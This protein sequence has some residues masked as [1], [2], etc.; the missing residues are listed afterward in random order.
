MRGS[1]RVLALLV[2]LAGAVPLNAD[3]DF[4]HK[5][6]R[7]T[8]LYIVTNLA[9]ESR[10]V[11]TIRS[12]WTNQGP[13]STHVLSWKDIASNTETLAGTKSNTNAIY[14]FVTNR[15]AET[16]DWDNSLRLVDPRLV[17]A[18]PVE[19]DMVWHA[20]WPK[21]E[22]GKDTRYQQI[23]VVTPT[24]KA[25]SAELTALAMRKGI[26]LGT[27]R[28]LAYIAAV[29]APDFAMAEALAPPSGIAPD[30]VDALVF[31]YA[32]GRAFLEQCQ[33]RNEAW[34]IDGS[35][36]LTLPAAVRRALP[37]GL[38]DVA[39]SE[40]VVTEASVKPDGH[41]LRVY[42]APVTRHLT[43]L[44]A[45]PQPRRI[46]LADLRDVTTIAFIGLRPE[47]YGAQHGDI[48]WVTTQITEKLFPLARAAGISV[49]ERSALE[50]LAREHQIALSGYVDESSAVEMGKWLSAK[51]VLL[52]VLSDLSP[53]TQWRVEEWKARD[54]TAEKWAWHFTQHRQEAARVDGSLRL[55]S[56]ETGEQLWT[57]PLQA[58]Y[59]APD[60]A[61]SEIKVDEVADRKPARPA[62]LREGTENR[63]SLDA[64]SAGIAEAMTAF[65][66]NASARVVWPSDGPQITVVTEHEEIW[67]QV[68]MSEANEV[69]VS[70]PEEAVAS[71]QP[72][73]TL[74][75]L[76]EV[77]V[78]DTVFY[79][80]KATLQITE[81]RGTVAA[82]ALVEKAGEATIA[83]GDP[84]CTLKEPATAPY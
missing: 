16:P 74:Y 14:I 23:C 43:S 6:E 52:G 49:V 79:R 36:W 70:F 8:E 20:V 28:R 72:G 53:Q 83:T 58:F 80:L 18:E 31:T 41:A 84:V 55:I 51:A 27:G 65:W 37:E 35:R 10:V 26:P 19:G 9:E 50:T 66:R 64:L 47:G 24:E 17:P 1:A 81:V 4:R 42:F 77:V 12:L 54:G 29:L 34:L 67:G 21:M 39:R 71:L 2:L 3:I 22:K 46:P 48:A 60:E 63:A 5:F 75:V 61:L 40:A 59:S 38:V 56:V 7:G 25:A 45:D 33:G 13:D 32:Q 30:M 11:G 15:G 82:C 76:R 62:G 73:M 78:G 44:L 69:F 68:E 57:A